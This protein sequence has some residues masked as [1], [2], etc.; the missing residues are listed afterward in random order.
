M[1]KIIIFFFLF[2]LLISNTKNVQAFECS[3]QYRD[4]DSG[5]C[6]IGVD[7]LP[8]NHTYNCCPNETECYKSAGQTPPISNPTSSCGD[9]AIS[10]ALGCIDVSNV[11]AL[12]VSILKLGI[13]IGGGI[14]FLLM[15]LAVFMIMTSAGDP[16]R[17]QAG[18]ELITS[19]LMGLLL[20]IFSVFLLQFIGI[21]VL[22]IPGFSK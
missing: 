13:G 10:T 19:A 12:T 14:A 3:N 22:G 15:L 6:S 11:N 17:L 1:K 21:T 2:L 18:Q 8:I 7:C 5:S 16:K 4:L 9:T 20:I